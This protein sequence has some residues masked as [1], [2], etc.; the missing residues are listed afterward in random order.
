MIIRR[1]EEVITYEFTKESE[2]EFRDYLSQLVG[3]LVLF[4]LCY[5]YSLE[6]DEALSMHE[7]NESDAVLRVAGLAR[8]R[9]VEMKFKWQ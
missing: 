6:W 1:E 2:E 9:N 4:K 8:E 7:S 3:Q 5:I